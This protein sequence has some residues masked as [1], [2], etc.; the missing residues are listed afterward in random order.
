MRKM[1]SR[2]RSLTVLSLAALLAASALA[3]CGSK[4]GQNDSAA[5]NPSAGQGGDD[6]LAGAQAQSAVTTD[7][8]LDGAEI[9]ADAKVGV[10][11]LTG[12]APTAAAKAAAE[13][14]VKK[15]AGVKS[16]VNNLTV[17]K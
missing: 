17:K 16:V 2:R 6:A 15:V 13:E 5:A 7:P 8:K 1:I 10:V 9:T 11:T 12:T 3:G 4:G 14:D